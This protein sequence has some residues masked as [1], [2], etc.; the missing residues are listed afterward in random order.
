MTTIRRFNID[1]VD[2]DFNNAEK[3]NRSMNKQNRE[4]QNDYQ[5]QFF[6]IDFQF[7]FQY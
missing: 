3:I 1:N 5:F 4:R 7:F 2:D 6:V